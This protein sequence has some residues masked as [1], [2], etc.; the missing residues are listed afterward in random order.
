MATVQSISSRLGQA[1]PRTLWSTLAYAR[2]RIAR[3]T[4]Q[5]KNLLVAGTGT[6]RPG[7]RL[8]TARHVVVGAIA[9]GRPLDVK[10][11]SGR[12]VQ[13]WVVEAPLEDIAEEIVGRTQAGLQAFSDLA[14]VELELAGAP[15]PGFAY[16]DRAP[17][18]G[19]FVIGL[20]SWVR[21][22]NVFAGPLLTP[23][24][25]WVTGLS[26]RRAMATSVRGN[27][28]GPLVVGNAVVGLTKGGSVT[29]APANTRLTTTQGG[30]DV[31]KAFE[32][33]TLERGARVDRPVNGADTDD[34]KTTR[35]EN[36]LAR[37]RGNASLTV[38]IG[39]GGG[40][41]AGKGQ[42]AFDGR[43]D[44][45]ALPQL[46][47]TVVATG[48]VVLV[49]VAWSVRSGHNRGSPRRGR[50]AVI[51]VVAALLALTHA[52]GGTPA[53]RSP[54]P[55]GARWCRRRRGGPGT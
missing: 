44:G 35:F 23:V 29:T 47:G 11:P 7:G 18:T 27:S 15:P 39:L 50:L 36:A 26:S 43:L 31:L 34:G 37:I 5:G 17:V 14:V 46:P 2:D 30:A 38:G 28:G 49:L 1:R 10:L 55:P 45:D 9:S 24:R 13:G 3:L 22:L 6:L 25:H 51:G 16:A 53:R 33:L 52:G 12:T 4:V 41:Y 54:R 8:I 40:T 42:S 48:V 20:G 32:H 19:D 21:E